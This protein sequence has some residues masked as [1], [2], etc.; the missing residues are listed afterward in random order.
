M[1]P[2]TYVVLDVETTGLD[3]NCDQIIEIAAI[4]LEK[5]QITGRLHTLINPGR[6][7]PPH[8]QKLTGIDDAMVRHAPSLTE[9]LPHLLDLM[10]DA[11]PVR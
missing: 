5:G 9:V 6:S 11:I 2:H 4:R 3:P 8:I 1:L 7:I 10:G